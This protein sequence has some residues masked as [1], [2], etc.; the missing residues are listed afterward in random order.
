MEGLLGPGAPRAPDDTVTIESKETTAPL[1]AVTLFRVSVSAPP[2]PALSAGAH[3][4]IMDILRNDS[5][6]YGA[7]EPRGQGHSPSQTEPN[8]NLSSTPY[9][10]CD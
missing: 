2:P 5:P 3:H 6:R 1:Q 4:T 10:L 8:G 7:G 9:Q